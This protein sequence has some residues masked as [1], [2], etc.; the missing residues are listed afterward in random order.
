MNF[1]KALWFLGCAAA[2]LGTAYALD[3]TLP[4]PFREYPGIEYTVGSIPLPPDYQEKTEWAF[5]RLMYPPGWNNGYAGRDNPD[6]S[7][8]YSLWTQDFP[9]ADRHFSLAVRRLTRI[10]VRSVEQI[11]NLDDGTEVYNWPWLYAVQVGE[12][13][14]T[15]S[16][17]RKLRDYLLRG[18]FFMADDFHGTVEWQVFEESMKRVFPDRPIV[19]I[20]NSDAIFHTVYD[21]DDRYQIVGAGHLAEGHKLDGY[22]ARWRGIYDDK[23]R[24][25]VAITFNSDV[26]D[27]WEWA[28]EPQYPERYSALGIRIGVNYIVY[29]MTH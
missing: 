12:W 6:W 4:H 8:G 28:D 19:D 2:F 7:Q 21:L 13:G 23:G 10:D 20:P 24:V 25:M 5:A 1:R 15:D 11:I 26:G 18:G 3:R 17:A 27:S 14:I 22:V 29:A 16:Q 9:R